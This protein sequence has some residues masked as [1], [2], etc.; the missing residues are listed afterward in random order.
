MRNHPASA[1]AC[2]LLDSMRYEIFPT[3]SI[4]DDVL[5]WLPAGTAVTVTASPSKPLEATIDLAVMLSK[6]GYTAMPHLAARMV[7]GRGELEEIADRLV[8]AGVD[9]VFVPGGDATTPR[10]AYTSSLDLL[11][12]LYEIGMPFPHV[13]VAGYPESHPIIA[14]DVT[15]QAMWDKRRFATQVV[16]NLCLEPQT[17]AM[18]VRRI[19]ARGVSLPVYVGMPGPTDRAKLLKMAQRIGVGDSARFLS[20]HRKLFARVAAPGGYRPERFLQRL[21]EGV[22]WPGA[23]VAGIHLYTFN[24][25]RAAEA[26]RQQVAA[27]CSAPS[28]S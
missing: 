23:G 19:R 14:D 27:R 10:G 22:D 12:D 28:A 9:R 25:V 3:R 18:W 24:Q 8:N 2:R 26:W 1:L 20:T 6:N 15:V 16:S 21:A 17:V 13:G 5:Q 7:R 4:G 11:Q